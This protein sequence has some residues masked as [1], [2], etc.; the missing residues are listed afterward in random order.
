MK[1]LG[2]LPHGTQS[3]ALAINSLG[4]VVGYSNSIDNGPAHVVGWTLDGKILDLGVPPGSVSAFGIAIND[5]GEIVGYFI[6]QNFKYQSFMWT[7][8]HGAKLLPLLPGGTQN[9]A[10]GISPQ[11]LIV[12]F[13]D[14]GTSGGKNRAVIW[15][16]TRK[17]HDLGTLPGGISSGLYAMNDL[18]QA[19]G[20]S[21]TSSKEI[22]AVLWTKS[23]GLQDLNDLIPPNSGW[24][25]NAAFAINHAG[26]ITGSGLINGQDHAYLLT[27]Q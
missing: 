14:S 5:S 2:T 15:N 22:H 8:A 13:A 27:P 25:L 19:V 7:K 21:T 1:N 16:L 24:T 23:G 10:S 12:G 20:N 18:G 26:Q 11:G 17:I 9:F 3:A 4:Q 6:T